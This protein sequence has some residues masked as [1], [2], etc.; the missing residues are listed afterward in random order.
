MTVMSVALGQ[1]KPGRLEDVLE[2]SHSAKKLIERHGGK[3]IRTSTAVVSAAAFGSVVN[4]SEFDDLE[5]YGAFFDAIWADEELISLLGQIQGANSPY[6]TFGANV[7][8]EIP[9]GRKR[10]A[11]GAII[12]AALSAPQPGRYQAAIELSNKAYDLVEASGARNCRLFSQLASGTLPDVL[13][14][15]MEY[16]SMR[17][18]GKAMS[19]LLSDPAGQALVDQVQSSD[20]PIKLLTTDVYREVEG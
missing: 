11:K 15:A 19:G 1:P 4:T 2:M 13:I 16:D 20:S 5:A 12:A 7:I 6:A 3:N 8:T 10:G 14:S 18:Y 9:L 17:A